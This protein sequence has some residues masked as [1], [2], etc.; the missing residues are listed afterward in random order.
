[1]RERADVGQVVVVEVKA[2]EAGRKRRER[3]RQARE[4]ARR[5]LEVA[6][7]RA[8][9]VKQRCRDRVARQEQPLDVAQLAPGQD[10]DGVGL[11]PR[12]QRLQPRP[13]A[14]RVDRLEL[15]V[16]G[17]ERA[18][19]RERL[20][21]E[22]PKPVAADLERLELRQ[23][24]GGVEPAQAVL[25]C[26][27]AKAVSKRSAER[28]EAGAGDSPS[29]RD[30]SDLRRSRPTTSVRLLR[31]RSSDWRCGLQTGR[32]RVVSTTG[33]H[34]DERVCT[35]APAGGRD[36][37][38]DDAVAGRAEAGERAQPEQRRDVGDRVRVEAEFRQVLQAVQL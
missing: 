12:R 36:V 17:V 4:L 9:L 8:G 3:G 32:V 27:G 26:G 35:N 10:E 11:R 18:Q 20:D 24:D 33:R 7:V 22:P 34:G 19:V 14:G 29:V 16:V 25:V 28:R 37:E 21:V 23:R 5:E 38:R 2:L 1:M 31:L 13:R 6:E 15:V 30:V